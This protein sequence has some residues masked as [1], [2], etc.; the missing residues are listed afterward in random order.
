MRPPGDAFFA[1]MSD[2]ILTSSLPPLD[3]TLLRRL[4]DVAARLRRYVVVRGVAGIVAFVLAAAAVQFLLDYSARGIRWSMRAALLFAIVA[5]VG[6]LIWR[7]ILA[8]LRTRIGL[9]DIANLIERRQPRLASHLISAIRFAAGE[10]GNAETNSPALVASVVRRAAE[11]VKDADFD[12]VLDPRG[13]RRAGWGLF[14][15]AA[16]CTALALLSPQMVGLWF[17]R[18]VLLQEDPWP[19]QTKL[20]VEAKDGV[21]VGAR[22]DDIIIMAYAEGVQPREVDIVY[23]T[24]GGASGRET[25]VTIGNPGAYRYRYTVKNAQEDLTFHLR[26]GDDRTDDYSLK[27]VERPRVEE[28]KMRFS[29]PEYTRL[30]AWELPDG[31]RAAQILPGTAVEIMVRTNKPVVTAQFMVGEDV[32]GEVRREGDWLRTLQRP[33]ETQTYHFALTDEFGLDDRQP[34]RFP[35]RV[36]KDDPPVVRMKLPG[37]GEMIT[38]EAV[39]PLELEFS[40]TYGL[41]AAEVVYEISREGFTEKS[42]ALP[43]FAPS[44]QTFTTSLGWPVA[45][46]SSAPGERITLRAQAADFDDVSGPNRSQSPPLTLRV[47]TPDEFLAEMARREQE[48]RLEFEKLVDAQEKLRGDLLSVAETVRTKVQDS[49]QL[50]AELT[51]LERRQRNIAGSVHV[52]RQQFERMLGERRVNRLDT[53]EE[54]ER[55]GI[56]IIEPLGQLISRDMVAAAD[57]L[58]RWTPE[59]A[60]ETSKVVDEQQAEIIGKMREVLATMVQWEG[61]QEVVNMLRDIMRLQGELNTE[62]R[63]RAQSEADNVFDKQTP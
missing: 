21:Q 36:T 18:N 39:L 32:A 29:P 24:A 55:L 62:T 14:G 38:P 44:A 2:S 27:L 58:R 48:A 20:K 6:F 34:A 26:G 40:D 50:A 42:I 45:V 28:S 19:R 60:A 10:S 17:A 13:A 37:V 8:P 56:R 23:E 49:E 63:Q 25:M 35:I 54:K 30:E 52:I 15:M 59:N 5:A 47:V 46:E 16:C 61:Y 33:L 3:A 12:G 51:P 9:A 4:A 1:D 41:A 43:D 57:A 7:L 22:G 31:Q 53:P 11:A